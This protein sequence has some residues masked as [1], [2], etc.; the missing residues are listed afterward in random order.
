MLCETGLLVWTLL[1]KH[2]SII[3]LLINRKYCFAILYQSVVVKNIFFFSRLDSF[4]P[5]FFLSFFLSLI[6]Y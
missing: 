5:S 4:F 1:N 6:F 3:D 2:G